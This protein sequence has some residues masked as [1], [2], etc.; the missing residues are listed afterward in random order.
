MSNRMF[1]GLLVSLLLIGM[2]TLA[3]DIQPARSDWTWNGTIY[4]RGDGSV[5]PSTAPIQRVGDLYV[6]TDNISVH[7][8]SMEPGFVVERDN[9]VID[10]AG[11]TIQGYDNTWRGCNGIDLRNRFNVTL[12][13]MILTTFLYAVQLDDARNITLISNSLLNSSYS[14]YTAGGNTSNNT[15]VDNTVNMPD[16]LYIDGILLGS[17]CNN[18]NVSNNRISGHTW[19]DGVA[20]S[21]TGNV[22]SGNTFESILGHGIL[23]NGSLNLVVNNSL[24]Y[25]GVGIRMWNVWGG[26]G[27]DLILDNT[28]DYIFQSGI[29]VVGS[30][31]IVSGNSITNVTTEAKAIYL[32]VA[33]DNVVC[34]NLITFGNGHPICLEFSNNN[35]ISS[36]YIAGIVEGVYLYKSNSNLFFHNNFITFSPANISISDYNVWDDGYSSGGNYWSDGSSPRYTGTDQYYGPNQ[37]I[38]GSDGIGDTFFLIDINNPYVGFVD[39]YP[40]MNPWTPTETSVR[41]T[42]TDYP[43]TIVSNTTLSQVI[44]TS[45]ALDFK[46]SGPSGE[47]G[48]INIIFPMVNTTEIKV[49]VDGQVLVPP[50]FPVINSNGTH[51][52][53]YFEFTLSTHDIEVQFGLPEVQLTIV[54]LYDSPNPTSGLYVPGTSVTASVTSPFAGPAGTQYVCTGWTG[55]GDVPPSGSGTTTTFTINQD[56]SITWNW[57]TQYYL[58]VKTDPSGSATIGG[59]GWYNESAGPTLTAPF[60]S[61]NYRFWG[62]DIDGTMQGTTNPINVQMNAPHTATAHYSDSA[63]GGEWAPANTLQLLTP[64][65]SLI[66]L[67]TI[68]TT[69]FVHIRRKRQKS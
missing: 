20:L 13:N 57:K 21:G 34:S 68:L 18:N 14:C 4:I 27:P 59:E 63:V 24:H 10:G 60:A 30:G 49:L 56:S 62:W 61:G 3:F 58:T 33:T 19:G 35:N 32:S 2:L 5:D 46:S 48:Y 38:P 40:L 23:V 67:M 9:I 47:K 51:Y 16:Y 54:S 29:E 36:N 39:F 17:G 22:I 69:S 53:I 12:K 15:I 8:A 66:S 25:I 31:I 43:V 37:D 55:T 64:L 41:V 26:I 28:I 50:P 7:A 45:C 1:S 65:I 11:Y 42:G 44:A 52:F 6:L